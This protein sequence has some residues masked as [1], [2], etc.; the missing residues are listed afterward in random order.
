MA[1]LDENILFIVEQGATKFIVA[2]MAVCSSGEVRSLDTHFHGS[3][4]VNESRRDFN[5]IIDVFF[6]C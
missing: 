6:K 4:A 1:Y 5:L 3:M 2:G